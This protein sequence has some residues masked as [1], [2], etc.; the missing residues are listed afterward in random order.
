MCLTLI[1]RTMTVL[2]THV[3]MIVTETLSRMMRTLAPVMQELP[4]QTLETITLGRKSG[5]KIYTPEWIF[6]DKGKEIT[7]KKNS[8]PTVAVANVWFSG[9]DYEGTLIVE[10]EQD[11]DWVGVV[12]SFQVTDIFKSL[13]YL[14]V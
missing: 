6:S 1:K 11:D 3:Q 7:Q 9:V 4:P 14:C 13:K 8:F 2:V 12:F 10:T 5:S